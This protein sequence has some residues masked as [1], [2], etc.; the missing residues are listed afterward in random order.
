MSNLLNN[1]RPLLR[2][3]VQLAPIRGATTNGGKIV[4]SP[5]GSKGSEV[6]EKDEFS[7]EIIDKSTH[8]GQKWESN[9]YRMARYIGKEKKV[10]PHYAIDLIAETAPIACKTRVTTCDGGGGPLGHPRVF[11]NLDQPGNHSC[12]YCGLR[13]YKEDHHH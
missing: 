9:D 11:I 13:F 5:S 4:S 7:F 8:T 10:N 6:T 1:G 12:G 3:L 2:R